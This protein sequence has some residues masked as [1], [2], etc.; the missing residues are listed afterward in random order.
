MRSAAVLVW[1]QE[2]RDL[3]PALGGQGGCSRHWCHDQRPCSGGLLA[4][5]SGHMTAA[6]GGLMRLPPLKPLQPLV[7]T[8]GRGVEHLQQ[9]SHLGDTQPDGVRSSLFSEAAA[10]PVARVATRAA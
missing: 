1:R 2:R 9:A 5:S 3:L 8:S 4:C 10:A 6:R 7:T